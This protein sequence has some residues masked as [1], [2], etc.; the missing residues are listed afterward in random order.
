[1]APRDTGSPR[2]DAEADFLRV[3]RQQLLANVAGKVRGHGE[4]SSQSLPFEEVVAAL[5]RV[6]ERNMGIQEIPV[7][8]IVGSVDKV[9]DF[10]PKFRPTS[11]RSRQ[12]WERI[13]LALRTGQTIPPI[14]VYQ[15]GDMYFVRDGHHRVSVC[16]ALDI[17]T[18]DADVT[19]VITLAEPTDVQRRADLTPKELRRA[20]LQRVPLRKSKRSALTLSEPESY[21][22]L[23]EMIE[24]WAARQMFATGE[25]MERAQAASRWYDE[26][27]QPVLDLID[28]Q[29][30]RRPGE[31]DGDVYMRV[32]GDRYRVFLEHI[33]NTEVLEVLR[34]KQRAKKRS[35]LLS[36]N[37]K[38]MLNTDLRDLVLRHPEKGTEPAPATEAVP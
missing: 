17:A 6:S 38:D 23:A 33:W 15:V 11:G 25:A 20:M 19:R 34:D 36:G 27:F 32:A 7:A 10:D 1:M 12:R 3:R 9:R 14:D 13:A 21:P 28:A 30:L 2:A 24:A 8:N 31:T 35:D 4:D 22:F 29:G 26:E 18:I 5:G 37:I 16:R